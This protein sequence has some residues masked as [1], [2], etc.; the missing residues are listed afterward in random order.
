[1]ERLNREVGV[2]AVDIAIIKND[3]KWIKYLVP[4]NV[5]ATVGLI[6]LKIVLGV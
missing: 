5:I 2:F 6:V 1:M 4:L 3:I